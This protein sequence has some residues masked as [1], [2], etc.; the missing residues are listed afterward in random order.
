ME[1]TVNV[2]EV[3]S[4]ASRYWMEDGLV[5]IMLGLTACFGPSCLL[6]SCRYRTVPG[7]P[8]SRISCPWVASKRFFSWSGFQSSG[9]SRS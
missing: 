5:E 3:T 4:R 1:P 7:I 8:L 2:D 9:D 6:L